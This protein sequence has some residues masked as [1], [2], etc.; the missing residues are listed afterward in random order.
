MPYLITKFD[1]VLMPRSMPED[2]LSTGPVD[3]TLQGSVGAVYDYAGSAR[4]WPKSH[5]FTHKGLYVGIDPDTG[6]VVERATV[7][8]DQRVTVDGDIRVIISDN[9]INLQTQT[10]DLKAKIGVRGQLWRQRISDGLLSWKR[11]RLLQVSHVEDVEK[12]GQVSEVESSFETMMYAWH[13]ENP[14]VASVAATAGVGAALSIINS[15]GLLP[16]FDGVL[17]ITRTSGTITAARIQGPGLD[18]TW[19]GSLGAGTSLVVDSGLN[20]VVTNPGG[21]DAYGG[22]TYNAAHTSQYFLPLAVGL[23]SWTV[24][25]TGG[26]GTAAMSFYAQWP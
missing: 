23:N 24:T 11:C 10:D 8:G 9:F 5:A 15:T 20:T 6:T 7:D 26:N 13:A 1:A 17:T 2:D 19:A 25:L 21:V 22:L 14:T 16:V 18:L 4:R 12:A 3:S